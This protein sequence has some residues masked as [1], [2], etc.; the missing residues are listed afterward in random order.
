MQESKPNGT[1]LL[2]SLYMNTAAHI[3]FA[4]AGVVARWLGLCHDGR[5]CKVTGQWV[6]TQEVPSK[7]GARLQSSTTVPYPA[8]P[9]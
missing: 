1:G 4:K 2:S 6:V 8:T 9:D 7:C 5:N 3:L